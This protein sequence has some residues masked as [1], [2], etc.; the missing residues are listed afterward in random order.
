MIEERKKICQKF[1]SV[2]KKIGRAT[3]EVDHLPH[4]I[5]IKKADL[6]EE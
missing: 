2:S 3:L 4:T 1:V 6:T 5:S